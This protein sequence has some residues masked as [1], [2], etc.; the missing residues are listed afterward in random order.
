MLLGGSSCSSVSTV[1]VGTTSGWCLQQTKS[2]P[3]DRHS[4]RPQFQRK[5]QRQITAQPLTASPASF[6]E[7]KTRSHAS[8]PIREFLCCIIAGVRSRNTSRQQHVCKGHS[9]RLCRGQVEQ[10]SEHGVGARLLLP[11]FR[12]MR[13]PYC[14]GPTTLLQ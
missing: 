2:K 6:F 9:A 3:F 10:I 8:F 5:N 13:C 14:C 4:P 11:L 12:L 7:R 1:F